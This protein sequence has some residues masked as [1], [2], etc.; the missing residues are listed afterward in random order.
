MWMENSATLVFHGNERGQCVQESYQGANNT[1]E[2]RLGY[3]GHG[4]SI[5]VSFLH[6]Q[7][8]GKFTG[9]T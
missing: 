6:F 3:L 7:L 4:H 5:H 2:Q 9:L 8:L 1:D